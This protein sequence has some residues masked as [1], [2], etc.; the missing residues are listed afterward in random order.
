[1]DCTNRPDSIRKEAKVVTG[2]GVSKKI[3]KARA[4]ITAAH[5]L[6]KLTQKVASLSEQVLA[7]E[8]TIHDLRQELCQARLQPPPPPPPPPQDMVKAPKRHKGLKTPK[9]LKP[10]GKKGRGKSGI[11]KLGTAGKYHGQFGASLITESDVLMR[12]LDCKDEND[13][14]ALVYHSYKDM[15]ESSTVESK[16]NQENIDMC[17]AKAII[18]AFDAVTAISQDHWTNLSEF[19][20]FFATQ[21]PNSNARQHWFAQHLFVGCD[22]KEVLEAHK[23]R[24]PV[25][26]K[27]GKVMGACNKLFAL[28]KRAMAES[29]SV[30]PVGIV[31][32]EF[33]TPQ[34]NAVSTRD[35]DSDSDSG[36]E[37][38]TSE[39]L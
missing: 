9:E 2:S 28:H 17:T 1:M 27:T 10:G 21:F 14:V 37:S 30:R 23:Y 22:S 12:E 5:R 25:F 29:H 16:R 18:L 6:E 26:R 7:H 24:H 4:K 36:S 19:K 35:V 31:M 13:L 39:P 3:E 32:N 8:K 34:A 38:D 11:Q 33:E 15:R 20:V